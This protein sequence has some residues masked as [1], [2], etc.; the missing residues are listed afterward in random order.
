MEEGT[1]AANRKIRL[2][3]IQSSISCKDVKQSYFRMF[4]LNL[5]IVIWFKFQHNLFLDIQPYSI[6]R[7]Q[8][9]ILKGTQP[10]SEK[11]DIS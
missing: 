2:E 9:Y 5:I 10:W 7:Y 1:G 11:I 6:Y 8:I 3:N 4:C